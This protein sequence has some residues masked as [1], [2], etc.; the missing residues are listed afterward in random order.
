MSWSFFFFFIFFFFSILF[1]FY[2]NNFHIHIYFFFST[3]SHSLRTFFYWYPKVILVRARAF[4][5]FFSTSITLF[6]ILTKT[7][8]TS[9]GEIK[10][11]YHQSTFMIGQNS[12]CPPIRNL[13][14]QHVTIWH[15]TEAIFSLSLSFF[16]LFS[17]HD[18]QSPSLQ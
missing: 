13:F 1:S 6:P 15:I 14:L 2:C 11:V 10:F 17:P 4:P 16:L 12:H 5:F 9:K 18:S 3:I 8:L 7:T